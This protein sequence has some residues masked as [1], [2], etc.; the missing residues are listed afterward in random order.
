MS[1]EAY[2]VRVEA[3]LDRRLSRWLWLVKWI[4]AVPHYIVLAFLWDPARLSRGLVLVKWWLLAI[5]QY[6][7]VGLFVGGGT[8]TA[9]RL[10]SNHVNWAGGV[11]LA[12]GSVLLI[13]PP[14]RR[15]SAEP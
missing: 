8:W 6:I 2:P 4:L 12:V 13:A 10:G 5:P 14:V 7:I 9:W 11:L 3:S 1:A 15:A